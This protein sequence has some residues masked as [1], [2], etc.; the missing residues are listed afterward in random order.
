[1]VYRV[2]LGEE[3]E[4]LLRRSG[5]P[6]EV[7]TAMLRILMDKPIS[8]RI[9]DIKARKRK[10]TEIK[11]FALLARVLPLGTYVVVKPIEAVKA[12]GTCR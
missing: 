7:S 11:V 8:R 6:R 4:K 10:G 2:K 12:E 3:R 9:S 1:M 5:L